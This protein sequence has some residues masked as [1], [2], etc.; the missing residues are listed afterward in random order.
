M[1][2]GYG[3]W[4]II[5]AVILIVLYW[6]LSVTMAA[7]PP[8]PVP[9]ADTARLVDDFNSYPTE[10]WF[11]DDTCIFEQYLDCKIYRYIIYDSN[12]AVVYDS[13]PD[14]PSRES[15]REIRNSYEYIRAI[16]FFQGAAIRGHTVNT[17]FLAKIGNRY[18]IVHIS[19]F[20]YNAE[21]IGFPANI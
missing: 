7:Q 14:Y 19:E 5:A 6:I 9:D 20:L 15:P 10:L 8:P 18:R 11:R 21:Q 2:V 4:I 16:G 17:A 13:K 12:G 3:V 1:T